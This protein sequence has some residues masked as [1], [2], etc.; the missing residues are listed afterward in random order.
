M[1]RRIAGRT[2]ISLLKL[3]ASEKYPTRTVEHAFAWFT[4]IWSYSVLMPGNMLSGP[5]YKPMLAIM[6]ESAWGWTGA[7]IA[8]L[9]VAALL[10]NGHWAPSPGFRLLGAAWG[11]GFWT[12]ISLCY[13]QGVAAGAADFPM[14]RAVFVVILFEA[15]SCYRCGYDFQMRRAEK[16]NPTSKPIRSMG[17]GYG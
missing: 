15:Y 2:G 3:A 13:W 12:L 4:L 9:R 1:I 17:A 16:I 8:I 7:A 11:I 6:P 10:G 5:T 14:R